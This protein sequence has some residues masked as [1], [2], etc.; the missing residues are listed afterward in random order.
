MSRSSSPSVAASSPR[1]PRPLRRLLAAVGLALALSL[2][3]TLALAD[4]TLGYKVSGLQVGVAPADGN[5]TSSFVGAASSTTHPGEFG[6]WHAAVLRTAF[7]DVG[8]ADIVG[9]TFRLKS[10]LRLVTGAFT[11]G[12]VDRTFA[13]PGC[14]N[15]AFAVHGTMT[16]AS[17]AEVGAGTFDATLTHFRRFIFGQCRTL[18]ASVVGVVGLV[19]APAP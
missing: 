6:L 5:F 10:N 13:A 17:G 7:N 9:G 8:H 2:L 1:G 12:T 11:G 18:G 15:E 4:T 16:A 14:G 3:P 19:L